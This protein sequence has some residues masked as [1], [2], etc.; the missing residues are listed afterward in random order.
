MQCLDSA[1]IYM[2]FILSQ[3]NS[4]IR[5]MLMPIYPTNITAKRDYFH[6]NWHQADIQKQLLQIARQCMLKCWVISHLPSLGPQC[7]I[8]CIVQ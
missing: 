4:Y 6:Y 7:K 8:L 5:S 1:M 3:P 2:L